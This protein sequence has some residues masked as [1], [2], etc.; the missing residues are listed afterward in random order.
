M[1]RTLL[2]CLASWTFAADT[3]PSPDGPR[4]ACHHDGSRNVTVGSLYR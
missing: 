2:L 3:L 4:G 1:N